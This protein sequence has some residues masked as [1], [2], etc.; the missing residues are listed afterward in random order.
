MEEQKK[1]NLP[2]D[3][4]KLI[5]D[6]C[7]THDINSIMNTIY[8]YSYK[9]DLSEAQATELNE[10]MAKRKFAFVKQHGLSVFDVDGKQVVALNKGNAERKVLGI[11]KK[12]VV[13]KYSNNYKSKK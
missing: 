11:K 3:I 5:C 4:I 1:V 7:A 12:K 9:Y 13:N 2:D 8:R 6:M 10:L